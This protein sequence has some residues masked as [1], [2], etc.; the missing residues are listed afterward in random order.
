MEQN[1][2]PKK[3]VLGSDHAGFERK[4]EVLAHLKELG[5]EVQD[6][7]EPVYN[8]KDD[9]PKYAAEVARRVAN[10]SYDRGIALCGSGIGASIAANRFRG[11]RAAL[12]ITPEMARMS[13]LHNN[14]NVLVLGGRLVGKEE[15]MKIVDTWLAGEF[16]GGRH[17]TRVE[18]L[19]RL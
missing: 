17:A 13:R 4:V 1:G 14:S 11:V 10:K 12:C 15:T 7:S 2:I 18:Q 3:I 19:D 6:V 8:P 9:Y 5:F 16:E